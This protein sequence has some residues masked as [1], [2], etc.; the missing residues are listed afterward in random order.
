MWEFAY[1]ILGDDFC[2]IIVKELLIV[3]GTRG[4]AHSLWDGLLF[5]VG[6][7]ICEEWVEEPFMKI[8]FKECLIMYIWGNL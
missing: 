1:D 5:L 8:S 3:P 4:I 2:S 6:V 7:W